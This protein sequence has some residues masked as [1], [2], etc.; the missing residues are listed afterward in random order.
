MQEIL[1]ISEKESHILTVD[2]IVVAVIEDKNPQVVTVGIQGPSGPAGPAGSSM[3][4]HTAGENLGGHKLVILNN[5]EKA[6]YASGSNVVHANKIIGITTGAASVNTQAE[7]QTY[8]ELS[9]PSWSW[10]ASKP[11]FAGLNGALTQAPPS[12]GFVQQVAS[13]I[14]STKIFINIQPAIVIA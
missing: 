8:G 12:S 5:S 4:L 13:V 2:D 1:V 9:E 6:L 14:S 3:V 7:I 11:L 10:D